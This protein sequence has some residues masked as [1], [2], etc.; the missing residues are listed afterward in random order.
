LTW[1]WSWFVPWCKS[2]M[3]FWAGYYSK[4]VSIYNKSMVHT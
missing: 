1:R 2:S 4:L 3:W